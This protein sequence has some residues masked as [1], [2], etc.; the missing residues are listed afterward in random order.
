LDVLA[1][2]ADGLSNGEIADRLFISPM[3]VDHHVSAVLAKLDAGTRVEAAAIAIH[4][5]LIKRK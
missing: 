5:G 4:S 1:L 2:I 3:T